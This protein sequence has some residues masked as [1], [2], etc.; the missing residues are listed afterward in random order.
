MS[1]AAGLTCNPSEPTVTGAIEE[2]CLARLDHDLRE[3]SNFARAVGHERFQMGV[4]AFGGRT[5]G[6]GLR[7]RSVRT[8]LRR[9]DDHAVVVQAVEVV[10]E[11][12]PGA[13]D[14]PY[15]LG[16]PTVRL[17][18]PNLPTGL[19]P[20][21]A[22]L[23]FLSPPEDGLG[24]DGTCRTDQIR[25][26]AP[27]PSPLAA[28]LDPAFPGHLRLGIPCLYRRWHP[29][30]D[31]VWVA[32]QIHSLLV[33]EPATMASPNDC[34][35]PDAARYWLA[36]TE[37]A[38]PLELPLGPAPAPRDASSDADFVLARNPAP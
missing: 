30:R 23:Y 13:G 26:S 33:V 10:A 16:E 17:R 15:P 29:Q 31:L 34:L 11:V 37:H 19:V 9:L 12:S 7:F 3:L 35:N 27:G 6:I 24:P 1:N 36:Q 25:V 4:A 20:F 38:V 28:I 22:N 21:L 14:A 8:G 2:R 32:R 5:L 18:F